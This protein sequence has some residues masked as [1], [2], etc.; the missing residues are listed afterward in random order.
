MTDSPTS[1][2]AEN[3]VVRVLPRFREWGVSVVRTTI[4]PP[5]AA[6]L[7][8]LLGRAIGIELPEDDPTLTGIV[9]TALSGVWYSVFRGIEVAARSPLVAKVA[10]VFLGSWKA[11]ASRVTPTTTDHTDDA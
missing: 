1:L 3:E 9:F 10:G 7:A 8:V 11:P 4:A 2:P 5:L 6:L